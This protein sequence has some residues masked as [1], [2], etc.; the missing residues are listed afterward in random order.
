METKTK[1]T[2]GPWVFHRGE[3]NTNDNPDHTYGSVRGRAKN[4]CNYHIARIW[5]DTKNYEADARLIAAAPELVEALRELD[6]ANGARTD[7]N[8]R[9]CGACSTC[10]ARAAIAKAEGR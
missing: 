1:H 7:C 10:R 8:E 9:K 2:P 6:P 5:S 3:D 4:G